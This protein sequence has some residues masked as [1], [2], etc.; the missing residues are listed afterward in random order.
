MWFYIHSRNLVIFRLMSYIYHT[1]DW[2]LRGYVGDNVDHLTVGA[3]SD[4]DFAGDRT[5]LRSTRGVFVSLLGEH[6][7]FPLYARSK[8]QTSTRR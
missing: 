1:K 8:K 5:D 2:I 4:A 3:W 6:T 7:D